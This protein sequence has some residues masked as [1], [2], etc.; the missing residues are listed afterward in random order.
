MNFEHKD[1]IFFKNTHNLWRDAHQTEGCPHHKERAT[2]ITHFR[3]L[4]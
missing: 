1:S 4:P 3:Q 2:L